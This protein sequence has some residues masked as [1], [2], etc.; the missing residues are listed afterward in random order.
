[1]IENGA[2]VAV[3]VSG[4][5]DSLS[6]LRLLDIRRESVLEQ[7]E[8][9][10]VHVLADARG[11][12]TPSPVELLEWLASSGYSYVVVKPEFPA[13]EA[14][15]MKCR[16][17]TWHRRH[18]LFETAQRLGCSVVA[19]GHT[20][21][22]L[23]QTTLL[24]LLFH[25]RVETM[26]PRREFFNGAIRLIRPLCYTPESDTRRF[27]RICAFPPPPPACPQA[28]LSRRQ[29][30]RDLI[31]QAQK[32]TPQARDN[33]LRAGLQGNLLFEVDQVTGDGRIE[34]G[35]LDSRTIDHDHP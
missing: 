17:C 13:N 28:G 15:P 22:D 26:S 11:P 19:M 4:G 31:R 8:L 33:L 23:A 10:A 7:Y 1:M 34:A 2:R 30:V 29:L 21:D 14:M 16:R 24:N 27:A 32:G 12:H 5:K 25:G 18:V 3:A 6:L 20:A 9:V 35:D